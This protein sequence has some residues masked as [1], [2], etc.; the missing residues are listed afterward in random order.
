MLNLI[1]IPPFGA[2]GAAIAFTGSTAVQLAVYAWNVH[3]TSLKI[4]LTDFLITVSVAALIATGTSLLP[5]H[6]LIKVPL[7]LGAFAL[8]AKLMGMIQWRKP[9]ILQKP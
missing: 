2:L 6:W 5:L 1:L 7:A 8:A 3:E 9:F 4:P